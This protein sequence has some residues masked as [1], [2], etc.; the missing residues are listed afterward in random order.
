MSEEPSGNGKER[1]RVLFRVLLVPS[2]VLV[3]PLFGNLGKLI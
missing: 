2:G 1:E 3:V